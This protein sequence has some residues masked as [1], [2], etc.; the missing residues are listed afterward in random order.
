M[1]LLSDGTSVV[2]QPG[3]S[4]G[5]WRKAPAKTLIPQKMHVA[6]LCVSGTG[7]SRETWGAERCSQ[8]QVSRTLLSPSI[9]AHGTLR[10]HLPCGE[11]QDQARDE[12]GGDGDSCNM[13]TWGFAFAEGRMSRPA[14]K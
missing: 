9:D 12:V 5:K 4:S 14:S 3:G 1:T 2:L 7:A 8:S 13:Q 10:A 6:G 11:V